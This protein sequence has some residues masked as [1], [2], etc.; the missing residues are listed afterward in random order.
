M[1]APPQPQPLLASLVSMVLMFYLDTR[2]KRYSTISGSATDSRGQWTI[3]GYNYVCDGVTNQVLEDRESQATWSVSWTL[4]IWGLIPHRP[5]V[6]F[7]SRFPRF[8]V[9]EYDSCWVGALYLWEG[10]FEA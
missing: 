10:R 4:T 5:P 8:G 9:L 1:G 3:H 6:T 7:P 2:R